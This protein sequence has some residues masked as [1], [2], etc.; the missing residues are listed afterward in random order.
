MTLRPKQAM[1][2]GSF[3]K[4][5]SRERASSAMAATLGEDCARPGSNAVWIAQVSCHTRF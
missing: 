3:F 1:A 4:V 2:E 5:A